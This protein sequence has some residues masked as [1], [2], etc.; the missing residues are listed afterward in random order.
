MT[1]TNDQII[2]L[3]KL[4]P[5]LTVIKNNISGCFYL[6]ALLKKKSKKRG[7][8]LEIYPWNHGHTNNPK[9]IIDQFYIDIKLDEDLSPTAFETDGRLNQWKKRIPTAFLH[10]N[11]DDSLCLG[12]KKE[13]IQKI[14]DGDSYATI[15]N[16]L[17]SNYFYYMS[18]AEKFGYEPW[19]GHRHGLL[20]SF[21]LASDNLEKNIDSVLNYLNREEWTTL[22]SKTK[23]AE[24][25]HKHQCP[26]CIKS[27]QIRHCF[28]H[29]KL[30]RGYNNFLKYLEEQPSK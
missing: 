28:S 23:G 6:S 11:L 5:E 21:E 26:F 25:K 27:T 16:N 13:I 4:Q 14:Q 24:L 3:K 22:L 29:K 20:A 12:N 19:E 10:V 8:S 15:L 9:H 18:H 30:V 1:L 2:E 7:A 17:L